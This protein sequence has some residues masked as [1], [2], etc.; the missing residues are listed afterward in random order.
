MP[1]KCFLC[2]NNEDL[3]IKKY[4]YWTI[5]IHPNQC[6]LGRCMV[7]LNRHIVDLFDTTRE[8]RDELFEIMTELRNALKELFKPDLFNYATLG[9]IVKHLHMHFIPRYKEKRLF[10]GIEF[11]DKRWGQ[12]YAPYNKE[13]KIQIS[14]LNELKELIEQKL[15]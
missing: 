8:E 9:N 1:Q 10:K 2:Q 15:Q 13:F 4:K 11:I 5:I 3:L 14:V 12:N 7:K 6:Y